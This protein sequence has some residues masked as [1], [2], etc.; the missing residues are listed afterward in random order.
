[1]NTVQL[2]EDY[3]KIIDELRAENSRL[4]MAIRKHRDYRGD[5]K[6]Y[7]DDRELYSILPEG[8]TPPPFDAAVELENCK[9]Y[10]ACRQDPST[11]YVSPQRRIEELE[12][13]VEKLRKRVDELSEQ[14]TIDLIDRMSAQYDEVALW[15]GRPYV[16]FWPIRDG[17]FW[18]TRA[19][20][21]ENE[22]KRLWSLP[23]PASA[24]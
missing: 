3:A 18:Y 21:A 16:E 7:M 14:G 9:K 13:E 10:I 20:L 12:A 15:D 6:C 17:H 23:T 11:T 22:V 4:M 19:I 2:I 5:D 8:Y 24:V 1:M